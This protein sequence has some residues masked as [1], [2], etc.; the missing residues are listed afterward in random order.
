MDFGVNITLGADGDLTIVTGNSEPII[1]GSDSAAL[2]RHGSVSCGTRA[3]ALVLLFLAVSYLNTFIHAMA[4]GVP[5]HDLVV[6]TTGP[7]RVA[8]NSETPGF[9]FGVGVHNSSFISRSNVNSEDSTITETNAHFAA[10]F[11][12]V[13]G[14]YEGVELEA[15]GNGH[16]FGVPHMNLTVVATSDHNI[17][18]NHLH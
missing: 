4:S 16:I 5:L 2:L 18:S 7:D 15:L 6:V 13:N 11:I 10:I 3:S 14:T 12:D 1:V 9:T 8:I 17:V